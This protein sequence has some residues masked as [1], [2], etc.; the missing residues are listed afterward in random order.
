MNNVSMK[1]THDI[2]CSSQ[3]Q[4][5]SALCLLSVEP[6]APLHAVSLNIAFDEQ[7]V[8]PTHYSLSGSNVHGHLEIY[9]TLTTDVT[10]SR[11]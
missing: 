4:I 5:R 10:H 11:A 9:S 3:G 8:S 2:A 1:L 6:R 7:F